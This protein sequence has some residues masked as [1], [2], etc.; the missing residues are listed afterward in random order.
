M[1]KVHTL[2]LDSKVGE[3]DDKLIRTYI[4]C[5]IGEAMGITNVTRPAEKQTFA[6]MIPKDITLIELRQMIEELVKEA[7]D[8][9]H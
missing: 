8:N 1:K 2:F 4:N 6:F 5:V 9:A 3:Y 7:V